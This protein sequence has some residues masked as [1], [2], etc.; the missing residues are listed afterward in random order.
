MTTCH[1]P[2]VL[3]WIYINFIHYINATVTSTVT[4]K[5]DSYLQISYTVQHVRHFS[6]FKLAKLLH[7]VSSYPGA[8]AE[9]AT[10]GNHWF[11]IILEWLK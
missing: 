1:L 3:I 2:N 4:R 10:T 5:L 11:I 7:K 9:N 8:T 6:F